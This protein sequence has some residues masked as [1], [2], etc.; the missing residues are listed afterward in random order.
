MRGASDFTD[1]EIASDSSLNASQLRKRYHYGGMKSD[2]ELNASQLRSRYDVIGRSQYRTTSDPTVPGESFAHPVVNFWRRYALSPLRLMNRQP[3]GI[4]KNRSGEASDG[5]H[6][7]PTFSEVRATI[8]P[9]AG[10]R[11]LH[12]AEAHITPYMQ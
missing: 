2:G 3:R 10:L 6:R 5:P 8:T 9:S 11:S 4:M 7:M 1:V 12:K